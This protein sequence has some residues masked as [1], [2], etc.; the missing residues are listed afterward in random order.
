MLLDVLLSDVITPLPDVFFIP[1]YPL[2][3]DV[4]I[5]LP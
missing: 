3:S 2:L 5:P 4:F 1:Y